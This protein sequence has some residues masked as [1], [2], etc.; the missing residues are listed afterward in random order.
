[1]QKEE[2]YD[3]VRF[4]D[5]SYKGF[6]KNL[7]EMTNSWYRVLKEYKYQDIKNRLDKLMAMEQFQYQPPTLPFL[8][9]DIP[10]V[11][12]ASKKNNFYQECNICHRKFKTEQEYKI[13]FERCSSVRYV[14]KQTKKWFKRDL[15]K[16]ELY[17][18]SE[19]EFNAR[20][21]KLIVHIYKH[22]ENEKE[23]LNLEKLIKVRKLNLE[24]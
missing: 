8:V 17:Q 3:L 4:V 14:M 15:D 22:T 6:V 13:H 24:G 9:K 2:V 16:R 19:E 7:E 21:N 23:K 1:M 10:T 18:M 20:Y 5:M 12:E 11:E